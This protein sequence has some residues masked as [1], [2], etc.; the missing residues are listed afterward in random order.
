M[1]GARTSAKN[2]AEGLAVQMAA[3]ASASHLTS[4]LGLVDHVVTE[5]ISER[6]DQ[7]DRDRLLLM[8]SLTL[9]QHVLRYRPAE[10]TASGSVPQSFA[11]R[12]GS[13]PNASPGA[14]FAPLRPAR[15]S[16]RIMPPPPPNQ[17]RTTERV[18]GW[19]SLQSGM[20]EDLSLGVL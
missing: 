17:P 13:V 8:A 11:V 20:Q 12:N 2:I 6:S 9:A 18:F 7:L 1:T 14:E 3:A 5:N 10:R 19:R 4:G 15:D 16:R